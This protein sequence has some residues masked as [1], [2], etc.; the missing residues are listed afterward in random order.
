[1][2]EREFSEHL[3][4]RLRLEGESE[5]PGSAIGGV[6]GRPMK[7]RENPV[8]ADEQVAAEFPQEGG[9]SGTNRSPKLVEKHRKHRGAA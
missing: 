3:E 1:M 2:A 6:S 7:R 5:A 8:E 4:E 9:M